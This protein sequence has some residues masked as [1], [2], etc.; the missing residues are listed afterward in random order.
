VRLAYS[1][2]P[3]ERIDEGIAR[4]AGVLTSHPAAVA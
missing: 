4:L 2:C 1:A 3:G